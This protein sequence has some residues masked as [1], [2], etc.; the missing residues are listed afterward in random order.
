MLLIINVLNVV[1]KK[2]LVYT[3]IYYLKCI[4]YAMYYIYIHNSYMIHRIFDIWKPSKS[5]KSSTAKVTTGYVPTCHM[6]T[7]LNPCRN[8]DSTIPWAAVPAPDH[9]FLE[10]FFPIS[11]LNLPWPRLRLF[12]LPLHSFPGSRG[13]AH[14]SPEEPGRWS[15]GIDALGWEGGCSTAQPEP[16]A[17]NSSKLGFE[18]GAESC[19]THSPSPWLGGDP[20]GSRICCHI[21]GL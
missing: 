12:L 13:W 9:P 7:A 3:S 19:P 20:R 14:W 15:C 17:G 10:E 8:G 5:I 21:L 16:G 11:H 2:M 1:I 6:H 18:L 4:L